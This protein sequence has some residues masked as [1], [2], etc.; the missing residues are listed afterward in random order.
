MINTSFLSAGN[1]LSTPNIWSIDTILST[2][3]VLNAKLFLWTKSV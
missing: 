3:N 2:A 1:V